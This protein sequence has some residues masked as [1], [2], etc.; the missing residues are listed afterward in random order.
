MYGSWLYFLTPDGW[1]IS[2]DAKDGKVRWKIQVADA[3]LQ[4]FTTMA[5]L[6]I[7][8]HVI[9]GVGGDAMDVPGYRHRAIP[10]PE[11]C[12][13]AGTRNPK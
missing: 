10:K 6:V 11:H 1:L 7:R 3:K 4:Y 12:S 9:V 5:P 2:F 13:G 8:D